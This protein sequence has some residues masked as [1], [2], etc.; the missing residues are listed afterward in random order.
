[1]KENE[2]DSLELDLNSDPIMNCINVYRAINSKLR[3]EMLSIIHRKGQVTVTEIFMELKVEQP[4]ASNHLAILRGAGLVLNSRVGKNVFY[5]VNY[6][7][8]EILDSGS[9]RLLSGNN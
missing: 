5:S 1:M 7:K 2:K 3:Q 8:L 6:R 4:V 9:T